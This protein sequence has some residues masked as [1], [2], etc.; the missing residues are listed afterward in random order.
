MKIGIDIRH[1]ATTNPSGVGLYTIALI[2]ML[3]K[4]APTDEF[5]LFAAGNSQGAMNRAPTAKNVHFVRI[6]WPNKILSLAFISGRLTLEDLMPVKLDAWWFPN[7]NVI[8]TKLPYSIT[9]HDL[10]F[11]FY[12]EFF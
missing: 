1:L 6:N 8:N 5:F 12:P 3:A 9:A 4:K 10:S 7:L 11:Q 2:E